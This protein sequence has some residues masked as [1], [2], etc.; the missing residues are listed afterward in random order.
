MTA[1]WHEKQQMIQ[2]GELT[3]DAFLDEL[4]QFIAERVNNIDLGTIKSIPSQQSAIKANCPMCG[5]AL[6]A[7]PKVVGCKVSL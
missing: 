3:V 1:L 5:K 2:G 7:T 6:F 4:E